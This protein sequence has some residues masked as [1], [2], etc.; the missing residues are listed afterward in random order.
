MI[1][2]RDF[3]VPFEILIYG[4]EESRETEGILD[5]RKFSGLLSMS[6]S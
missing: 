1:R 3:F 5:P 4:I 6:V 2:G